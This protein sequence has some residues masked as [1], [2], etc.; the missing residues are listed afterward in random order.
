MSIDQDNKASDVLD[1]QHPMN[2]PEFSLE[3]EDKN[4]EKL[5][6][7]PRPRTDASIKS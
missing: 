4:E 2:H 7:Q 6:S 5:S 1:S 3:Y